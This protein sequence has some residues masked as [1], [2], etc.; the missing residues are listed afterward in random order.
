MSIPG[1]IIVILLS[2]LVCSLFVR[3]LVPFLKAHQFMDCPNERSAHQAPTPRGGGLSIIFTLILGVFI[4]IS[5]GYKVPGIEL[6]AALVLMAIAGLLDD[7]FSLPIGVRLFVQLFAALIVY[8]KIGGF[9]NFPLPEPL[10]FQLGIAALPVNMLWILAVVNIFNFLD[11]IDGY[12][13]V[14]SVLAGLFLAIADWMG[15]VMP[16]GLCIA[17]ASL[18]YLTYNWHPAKVFMGDVG[19]SSLGFLFACLPFYVQSLT[20]EKSVFLTSLLLWFFLADGTFTLIRRAFRGEKI[21]V[22]H[23]SHLYQR[24]TTSGWSQDRVVLWVMS[25][26]ALLSVLTV[27]NQYFRMINDWVLLVVAMLLFGGYVWLSIRVEKLAMWQG[28]SNLKGLRV[29]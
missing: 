17:G 1:L 5:L 9:E 26:S 25:F 8:S 12:A 21:W 18:G 19:S 20:P 16:V 13:A 6:F 29:S 28:N 23:R 2:C 15:P 14:Q 24:L 4:F 11:G 10:N 22:P 27:A 3:C 7:R